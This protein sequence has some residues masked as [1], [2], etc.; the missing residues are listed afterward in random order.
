[1][2]ILLVYF[3]AE[4]RQLPAQNV[5]ELDRTVTL[6]GRGQAVRCGSHL[7]QVSCF[8]LCDRR[9]REDDEKISGIRIA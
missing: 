5:G 7:A 9:L 3:R 2:F 1:M 8:E 4:L 6:E